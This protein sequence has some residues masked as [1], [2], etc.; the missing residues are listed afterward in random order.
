MATLTVFRNGFV[1]AL[2]LGPLI[3]L[4][5][6]TALRGHTSRWAWWV[7]AKATTWLTGEAAHALGVWLQNHQSLPE[8]I[9]AFFPI[10]A[11][12]FYG[13]WMLWVTAPQ[14]ASP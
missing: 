12:P 7:V 3:G 14:A 4:A 10:L 11:L 8:Q 1:Q 2:V 9:P 5:Q 6:T 13:V